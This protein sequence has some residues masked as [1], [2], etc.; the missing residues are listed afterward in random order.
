VRSH[1]GQRTDS[2]EDLLLAALDV[3]AQQLLGEVAQLARL[4]C[5]IL[6]STHVSAPENPANA[7]TAWRGPSRAQRRGTS[8]HTWYGRY[9]AVSRT[10]FFS[11]V[12]ISALRSCCSEWPMIILFLVAI[13]TAFCTSW[14]LGAPLR[15]CG[16]TPDT[17]VR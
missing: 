10:S 12:S 2:L 8:Y 11:C 7:S 6:H 15:S 5:C 1:G 17:L 16:R 3:H 4:L 14:K 9:L 13:A